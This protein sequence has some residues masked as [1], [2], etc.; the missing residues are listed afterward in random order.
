MEVI[1]VPF[2]AG[3]HVCSTV[4]EALQLTR[5]LRE[6]HS[7]GFVH[8]DIRALNIVFDGMNTALLDYDFGGKEGAVNFPPGYATTLPDGN[9]QVE[10]EANISKLDDAEALCY[11]LAG[12]HVLDDKDS[13]LLEKLKFQNDLMEKVESLE[14]AE[15][16]LQELRPEY[17]VRPKKRFAKFMNKLRSRDGQRKQTQEGDIITPEKTVTLPSK[18]AAPE[19]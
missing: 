3:R 12:L 5:F 14:E 11:V 8:G 19:I 9:R 6:M 13:T 4:G 18:R 16:L 10:E 2:L 7:D 1:A 15:H 17:I